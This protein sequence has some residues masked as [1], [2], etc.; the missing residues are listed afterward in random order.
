[1]RLARL[2]ADK[3]TLT[4][5]QGSE[6]IFL[7]GVQLTWVATYPYLGFTVHEA[8]GPHQRRHQ[9]TTIDKKKARRLCWALR[10]TFHDTAHSSYVAPKALRLAIL[11]VV[12]A[13]YLYQT[14]LLDIDYSTLDT[15]ILQVLKAIFGLP[16]TTPSVLVYAEL[17]FWPS[18]YHGYARAMEFLWKAYYHYWTRP[19]F[20]EWFS[21]CLPPGIPTPM[22][23]QWASG[24]ILARYTTILH[25]LG[26]TWHSLSRCGCPERW[27]ETVTDAITRLFQDKCRAAATR[28]AFP[29]LASLS[30][31]I[32]KAVPHP[33]LSGF[34]YLRGPLACAVF[35]MRCPRLRLL[36]QS[37]LTDHGTCR[38]CRQGP[39]NGRHLLEC[40]DLPAPLKST[41][42]AL[43]TR[44]APVVGVLWPPCHMLPA[45]QVLPHLLDLAWKD[46]DSS[47]HL[48]LC[49]HIAV[50]FRDLLKDYARYQPSW[51]PEALHAYPVQPPRPRAPPRYQVIPQD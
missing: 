47:K 1:M 20:E 12:H 6:K 14:P 51:E 9:S 11:Q 16:L 22:Q 46:F 45:A 35:R 8:P 48:K 38:Y 27:K 25:T 24:G 17:G 42:A 4:D 7:S 37:D 10:R 40:P 29:P 50:F 3:R 33:R 44:V 18:E 19:A 23:K 13:K 21:D 32:F 41:R 49:Q 34:L 2:P 15:L 31:F 30:S 28:H 5:L 36:P 26:L 43:T 39:E